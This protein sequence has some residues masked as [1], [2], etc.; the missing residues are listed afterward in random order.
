LDSDANTPSCDAK[1]LVG[2]D[3]GNFVRYC[4]LAKGHRQ[5][6]KSELNACDPPA[7]MRW[8]GTY[9]ERG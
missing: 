9:K 4:V 8:R 1:I 3:R 5:P 2:D 7:E 6:H